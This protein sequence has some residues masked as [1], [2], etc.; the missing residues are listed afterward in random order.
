[1]AGALFTTVAGGV[2][3]AGYLLHT[4]NWVGAACVGFLAYVIDGWIWTNWAD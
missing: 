4:G 2:I 1:M 3:L